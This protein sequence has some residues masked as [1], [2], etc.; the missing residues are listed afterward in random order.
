LFDAHACLS[1]YDKPTFTHLALLAVAYVRHTQTSES[2]R[3]ISKMHLRPCNRNTGV[4]TLMAD[5]LNANPE[6]EKLKLLS[7]MDEKVRQPS[8]CER[9]PK[10]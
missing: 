4:N 7:G 2:L 5:M 1:L 3:A 6:V 9:S 10:S 8:P